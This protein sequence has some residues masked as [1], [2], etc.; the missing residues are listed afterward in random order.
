[1]NPLSPMRISISCARRRQLNIT[2]QGSSPGQRRRFNS[3]TCIVRA[4]AC[5]LPGSS[6]TT[7][8]RRGMSKCPESRPAPR[9][10]SG[11][12]TGNPS[13]VVETP[14]ITTL[15]KHDLNRASR[16]GKS[17]SIGATLL[18][19]ADSAGEVLAGVRKHSIRSFAAKLQ[20]QRSGRCC[21]SMH[22]CDLC[23]LAK[24]GLE[25][26]SSRLECATLVQSLFCPRY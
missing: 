9:A 25:Q 3:K 7:C 21:Q 19:I 6:E 23:R 22:G 2:P 8:S 13:Q 12:R 17:P 15:A 4:E 5:P 14:T 20:R 10:L 16:R 1:M 26:C 11:A 18:G 24:R